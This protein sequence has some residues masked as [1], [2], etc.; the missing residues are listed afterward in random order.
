MSYLSSKQVRD[1]N[2]LYESIYAEVLTEEQQ[3][4]LFGM[5]WYNIMVQEGLIEGDIINTEDLL[6]EG[7]WDKLGQG[8]ATYG[9]K[10]LNLARKAT[11]FGLGP[12]AGGKRKVFTAGAG[13]AT[14]LDPQ[15]AADIVGG[16]VSGAANVA[17][18]AIKGGIEAATKKKPEQSQ[19]NLDLTPQ[20]TIRV[21]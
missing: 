17:S 3:N 8:I 11:G 7:F 9:P 4:N 16:T 2:S 12:G 1:I 20:G 10:A 14:A 18:G 6:D 21:R 5:E 19:P 15:K 13:T